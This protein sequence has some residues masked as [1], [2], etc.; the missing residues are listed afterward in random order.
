VD[1]VGCNVNLRFDGVVDMQDGTFVALFGYNSTATSNV[2]PT[3]NQAFLNDELGANQLPPATLAPGNHPGSF[4][5]TFTAGQ[6]I[7]WKVDGQTETTNNI[8][9]SLIPTPYGTGLGVE[10]DGIIIMLK[11]DLSLK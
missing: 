1:K 8:P 5:P 10:V 7:T 2:Q 11:P 6:W 3:S 4:L 9:P